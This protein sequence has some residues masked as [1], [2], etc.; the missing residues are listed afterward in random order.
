M[1]EKTLDN[2]LFLS[3]SLFL[4]VFGPGHMTLMSSFLWCSIANIL[5]KTMQKAWKSLF[6]PSWCIETHFRSK[7]SFPMSMCFKRFFLWSYA[8]WHGTKWRKWERE[9]VIEIIYISMIEVH[10]LLFSYHLAINW[11][12]WWLST[13]ILN[14]ISIMF[15]K[16]FIRFIDNNKIKKTAKKCDIWLSQAGRQDCFR[17]AGLSRESRDTWRV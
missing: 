8:F 13:S 11:W 1:T 5:Q 14:S 6:L 7:F 16:Y 15:N 12:V 17:N 9:R 4:H 10:W 2:D 3:T